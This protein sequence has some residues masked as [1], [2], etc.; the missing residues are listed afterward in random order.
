MRILAKHGTAVLVLLTAFVAPFAAAEEFPMH[1]RV[2]FDAGGS[3]VKGASDDDWSHATIN[4]L[5]LPG[6]TLWVDK[7]GTSEL[8][9]ASGSFLRMADGSKADVSALP[10]NATIRG[11]EGSFYLQRLS[12][13]S[14]G[15]LFTT[16]AANIDIDSDAC[17]R[18]DIVGAGATTV[19]VRWGK[20][21]VR[22]ETGGATA[23]AGGQRCWVDPGYLPSEAQGFDLNQEDAFDVWNRER[24]QLLAE[25]G[26]S[27]PKTVT[28]QNSTIGAAD[29]A[30]TGE[31]VYVE[32]RPYWR[33]TVVTNYVPY[34]SGYWSN[35]PAIGSVWVED[36]PF[37]Y[38]TSHY[39]RWHSHQNYG[40][41]WSY[42]PV[43]SPAW[44]ATIR[45][46]D[47]F[48][49]TPVDYY[50]RPVSVYQSAYFGVGG[51]NFSIL[52]SSW[53]PM[54]YLYCNP[55]YVRPMYD[56]VVH[57]IG[58]NPTQ[59]N[60]W[61]IYAGRQPR[62]RVPFD[63]S[64]TTVRD[65]SP[66][67]SIRGPESFVQG[68]PA[69]RH[70]VT[71]LERSLGRT[72]FVS[73][74]RSGGRGERTALASDVRTAQTRSVRMDTKDITPPLRSTT[75]R[76]QDRAGRPEASAETRG[77]ERTMRNGTPAITENRRV[78]ERPQQRTA[79]A[80]SRTEAPSNSAIRNTRSLDSKSTP[81]A[82]TRT[83]A[84]VSTR[85]SADSRRTPTV[86]RLDMDGQRDTTGGRP[87][88]ASNPRSSVRTPVPQSAPPS[89]RSTAPA[90]GTTTP[91][92]TQTP[93]RSVLR[94]NPEPMPA[95]S[96]GVTRTEPRSMPAPSRSVIRSTP[97][98][99]PTPKGRVES[100]SPAPRETRSMPAP[101]RSVAPPAPVY[102]PAP[103]R[104]VEPYSPAPREMRPMP[105]PQRSTYQA[106]PAPSRSFE[107]PQRSI[108]SAPAPQPSRSVAEPRSDRSFSA[109][110]IGRSAPS[111]GGHSVRGSRR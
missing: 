101:Q 22:T 50:C 105:A 53:A 61:N 83:P 31:W 17:V 97:D 106:A 99:S 13:S 82:G 58:M 49:W 89:T 18:V 70:T 94:S 23:L 54:P 109:P 40:W 88:D 39:G 12:R 48:V 68:G 10:P 107:Q 1:A 33:P 8:E 91:S 71:G 15:F 56:N 64:V 84:P 111:S 81:P 55:Y 42:D 41:M 7:G 46:G 103:Q 73:G 72:Q 25:G 32:N 78:I 19:S 35:V 14:G 90:R 80:P 6:D 9:L 74:E 93:E 47:F 98:Y 110:G 37:A 79:S 24:S 20:A 27:V 66:R 63:H 65:Y 92:R 16:P 95:P 44:A 108:Q 52:A 45:C 26:K 43:W 5:V 86:A 38:V 62:V 60:I 57:Y 2:S 75:A 77:T 51:L 4:T 76:A 29:L 34:R 3:M 85:S 36:Y 100:Y 11:W 96:R 67:R 87:G 28:I 30:T 102:T 21:T 59:I 104:Q 69:A